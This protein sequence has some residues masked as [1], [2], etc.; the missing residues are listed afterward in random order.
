MTRLMRSEKTVVDHTELINRMTIENNIHLHYWEKKIMD[1]HYNNTEIYQNVWRTGKLESDVYADPAQTEKLMLYIRYIVLEIWQFEHIHNLTYKKVMTN[2]DIPD[3]QKLNEVIKADKQLKRFITRIRNKN[4]AH[5]QLTRSDMIHEVETVGLK[6]IMLYAKSIILFQD[7]M[8]ALPKKN[9]KEMP[10]ERESTDGYNITDAEE[11]RIR[12]RYS[13]AEIKINPTEDISMYRSMRD[14]ASSLFL[15]VGELLPAR[16]RYSKSRTWENLRC[17]SIELYNIKYMVLELDK[18]IEQ[19]DKLVAKHKD[20]VGSFRPE[21]LAN[22][23]AYRNIRNMYAA[24]GKI[25]HI[26]GF[27]GLMSMYKNLLPVVL[28]DTVEIIIFVEKL[29]IIFPNVRSK[30]KLMNYVEISELEQEIRDICIMTV[31]FYK[32]EM[33]RSKH[34]QRR[35]RAIKKAIAVFELRD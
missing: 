25:D 8:R 34:A 24:H 4:G 16:Q 2:L 33:M 11:Q 3:C 15:L 22:R 7:A 17:S 21:F 18:F 13:K 10:I 26:A 12:K 31:K 6:A 1:L 23:E 9:I 29:P 30:A 20:V 32:K 19:F 14:C 5:S 35:A 27:K 28:Q